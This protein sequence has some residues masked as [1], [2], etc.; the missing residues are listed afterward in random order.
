[1]EVHVGFCGDRSGTGAG[2]LR[3]LWFPLPIF[4]A[5]SAPYLLIVIP[6]TLWILSASLN[7]RLKGSFLHHVTEYRARVPGLLY[8][9]ALWLRSRL[10][11]LPIWPYY[12]LLAS[13][14]SFLAL[15][16]H[17]LHLPGDSMWEFS[18]FNPVSGSL[19]NKFIAGAP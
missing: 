17:S 1:M 13:T 2:F 8:L 12:L 9:L 14:S 3:V 7:T 18:L 5:L 6:T 19:P 15:V 16:N 4:I 11:T 10:R